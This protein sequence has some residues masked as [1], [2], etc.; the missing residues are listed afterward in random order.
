MHHTADLWQ[1]IKMI[2]TQ[3]G[4]IAITRK[5]WKSRNCLRGE[6]RVIGFCPKRKRIEWNFSITCRIMHE[7]ETLSSMLL[8][9]IRNLGRASVLKVS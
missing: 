3:D 4:A 5:P 2:K 7:S 8:F 6:F 1:L 9:F